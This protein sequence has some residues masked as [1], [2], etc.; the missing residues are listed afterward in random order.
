MTIKQVVLRLG[1]NVRDNVPNVSDRVSVDNTRL[2]RFVCR[3]GVI[4]DIF[5][6]VKCLRSCTVHSE[7]STSVRTITSIIKTGVNFGPVKDTVNSV[8]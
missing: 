8:K 1:F 5:A 7:Y 4:T 3:F 2:G 6:A